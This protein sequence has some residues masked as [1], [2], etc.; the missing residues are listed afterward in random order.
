MSRAGIDANGAERCL[1]HVIPW[2][3]GVYDRHEEKQRAYEA[4]ASQINRIVRPR[5]NVVGIKR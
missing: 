5:A 2:V 1:G 4:L 3:R